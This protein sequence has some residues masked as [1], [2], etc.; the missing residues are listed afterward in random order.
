VTW[1]ISSVALLSCLGTEDFLSQ[2]NGI[3]LTFYL[4]LS[5]RVECFFG[6]C[7][8]LGKGR[9][10]L[11]S[12]LETV[13]ILNVRLP[14]FVYDRTLFG[15]WFKTCKIRKRWCFI[16]FPKEWRE[17]KTASEFQRLFSWKQYSS[18]F[19]IL[20]CHIFISMVFMWWY[21]CVWKLTQ[22]D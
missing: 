21:L 10:T 5:F 14:S 1:F 13:L 11:L 3:F 12:S 20:D 7:I 2:P 16:S 8:S 15:F 22:F 9:K 19:F 17:E 18:Y 6:V 4:E